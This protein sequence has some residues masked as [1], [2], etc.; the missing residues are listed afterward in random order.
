MDWF[1]AIMGRHH[2][3]ATIY[4]RKGNTLSRA[5]NSYTHTHPIQ[6]RFSK[7]AGMPERIYLHA[8]IAALV[9]LRKGQ[10]PHKIMIDRRTKDGLP[11]LA[12]PCPVCEAAIRFWNIKYVQYSV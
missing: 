8:E 10:H 1:A 2:V 3:A 6:A 9:K 11:A 5:E 12:K 7:A 4:D